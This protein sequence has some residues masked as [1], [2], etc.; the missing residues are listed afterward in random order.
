MREFISPKSNIINL[1]TW[2]NMLTYAIGVIQDNLSRILFMT[3]SS[4]TSRV[5]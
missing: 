5:R 1:T 4:T 3:I 2:L